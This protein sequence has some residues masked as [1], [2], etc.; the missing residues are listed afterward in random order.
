LGFKQERTDLTDRLNESD[1]LCLAKH[2]GFVKGTKVRHHARTD[3][4]TFSDVKRQ[5]IG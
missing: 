2:A 4:D 5:A 1:A 3:I